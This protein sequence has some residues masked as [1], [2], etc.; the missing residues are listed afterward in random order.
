MNADAFLQEVAGKH[1]SQARI[2][3]GCVFFEFAD[4]DVMMVGITDG[5]LVMLIVDPTAPMLQ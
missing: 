3:E 1:I 4:G 2:E 5:H